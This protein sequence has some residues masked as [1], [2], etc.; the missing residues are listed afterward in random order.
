MPLGE[1]HREM[2]RV[3]L[4]RHNLQRWRTC[5]CW[6]WGIW[7]LVMGPA[8]L[9]DLGMQEDPAIMGMV[10]V[11][12]GALTLVGAFHFHHWVELRYAHEGLPWW[13]L[14]SLRGVLPTLAAT[15]V[16]PLCMYLAF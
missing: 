13:N 7:S 11:F 3:V 4:A 15:A 2:A 9:L 12:L 8:M 6:N 1:E 10:L 5:I 14:L 16:L